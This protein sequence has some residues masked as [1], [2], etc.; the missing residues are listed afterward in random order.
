MI[1]LG[2]PQLALVL[3]SAALIASAM[4]VISRAGRA[5]RGR[6]LGPV[7]I[8]GLLGLGSGALLGG[9]ATVGRPIGVLLLAALVLGIATGLAT[10]GIAYQVTAMTGRFQQRS[11]APVVPEESV[12][13]KD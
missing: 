11:S 1:S 4:V 8:S 7:W 9:A 6:R 13:R 5:S 12:D 3:L 10:A 2:I